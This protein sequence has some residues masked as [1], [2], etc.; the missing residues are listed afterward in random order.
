MNDGV[1]LMPCSWRR[2]IYLV[3]ELWAGPA[4]WSGST[5]ITPSDH[6]QTMATLLQSLS[7]SVIAVQSG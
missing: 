4:C 2:Y 3:N 5:H 1:E 6:P 7:L